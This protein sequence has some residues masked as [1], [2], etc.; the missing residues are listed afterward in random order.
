MLFRSDRFNLDAKT[1]DV[2]SEFNKHDKWRSDDRLFGT[3]TV[4]YNGHEIIMPYSV[5][6]YAFMPA[7]I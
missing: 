6:D 1:R 7:R 4:I 3:P 5:E 2:I